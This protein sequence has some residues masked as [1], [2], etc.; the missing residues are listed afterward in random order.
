MNKLTALVCS[1]LISSYVCATT[2]LDMHLT[3]ANQEFVSSA[4]VENDMV[5]CTLGAFRV[6]A[7]VQP[8]ENNVVIAVARIYQDVDGQ[9]QLFADAIFAL[10]TNEENQLKLTDENGNE[11]FQLGITART[12]AE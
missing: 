8:G 3:F 1:L 9:S 5:V 12:V 6:E 11:V 10:R 7:L 2:Q 4:V